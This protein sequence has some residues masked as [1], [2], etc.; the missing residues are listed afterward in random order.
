LQPP[1]SA[2]VDVT[3]ADFRQRVVEESRR[4]PVLVD[5][6]ADW[7]GPCK[8]LSPVL[9]RLAQ[10]KQGRFLLAKMDVDRNQYTAAQFRIQSIPNVWAF[11]DGRPVDQFIGA[12]PEPAV[13]EFLDRLLP[14]E[15]DLE[16][17]EA[18]QAVES[19]DVEAAERRFREVLGEDQDNREARLG[20]GR[21]L[22]ER[23]DMDEARELLTPLLPDPEAER[24]LA[25]VRVG[26]WAD[27]ADSDALAGPRRMAAEGR[28]RESLDAFLGAVRFSPDDRDAAREAMVDV[29]AVLGDDH[30]LTREYRGK[31]ASALF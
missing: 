18:S 24:L 11:V 25:V 21:I 22:A 10:E 30:P 2:V 19:G 29:F 28:W 6:W 20:L 16:A 12:L 15:A 7:C 13:R 8:Q 1:P 4:R 27:V 5:F 31:L 23:G 9:E 26:G 3:D 17:R 14:T